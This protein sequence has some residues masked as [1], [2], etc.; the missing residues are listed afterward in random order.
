MDAVTS[1]AIL[2]LLAHLLAVIAERLARWAQGLHHLERPVPQLLAV[3]IE[4]VGDALA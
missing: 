2:V 3:L 4:P 1:R